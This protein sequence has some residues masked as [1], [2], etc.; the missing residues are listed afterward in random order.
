MGQGPEPQII[1]T[2]KPVRSL[3]FLHHKEMLNA[4]S[5]CAVLVVPRLIA[6]D[7]ARPEGGHVV[8]SRG[9]GVRAFMHVE[10]STH[11]MASAVAVVQSLAPEGEPSQRVKQEPWRARR[12]GG[13]GD[14]DVALQHTGVAAPLV[15]G[16]AAQVE[17]P[18]RVSRAAVVLA[19]RVQQHKLLV[20][21]SPACF[22]LRPVVDDGSVGP[23]PCDCAEAFLRETLLGAP[24]LNQLLPNAKLS[25]GLSSH[26]GPLNPVKEGGHGRAIPEVRLCHALELGGVLNCLEVCQRGGVR[27]HYPLHKASLGGSGGGT[28]LCLLA[29]GLGF[30]LLILVDLLGCVVTGLQHCQAGHI[31]A[32]PNT[33]TLLCTS[34]PLSHVRLHGLEVVR[35][36][37]HSCVCQVACH[38][39]VDFLVIHV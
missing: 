5:E 4:N 11:T 25:H 19:S 32:H 16:G 27:Q 35:P 20:C 31:R 6:H 36:N 26:D 33:H 30:G 12:E 2:T 21:D 37:S 28:L 22:L 17:S 1:H 29:A 39:S 3:L 34:E 24:Q 10:A 9:D 7:H 13:C 23:A 8:V 18:G 14:G 15:V 38:V